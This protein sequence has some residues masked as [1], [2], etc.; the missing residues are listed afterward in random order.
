ME[1]LQPLRTPKVAPVASVLATTVDTVVPMHQEHPGGFELWQAA[2]NGDFKNVERA[3]MYDVRV[4]W[5]LPDNDEHALTYKLRKAFS[6]PIHAGAMADPP[7]ASETIVR[8]LLKA[9]ASVKAQCKICSSD[10]QTVRDITPMHLASGKGNVDTILALLEHDADVNEPA[11]LNGKLHYLPIHDAVWFN[12]ANSMRCL[13][14]KHARIEASNNAGNTALHLAAQLGHVKIA[15]ILLCEETLP[16]E[17]G[18][19]DGVSLQGTSSRGQETPGDATLDSSARL[20]EHAG[21]M[22]R[23]RRSKN[24]ASHIKECKRLVTIKNRDGKTPLDLAVEK[25]QFPPRELH[26]F[27]TCLDPASKVNAFVTIAKLCPAAAPALIRDRESQDIDDFAYKS[28]SKPWQSSLRDG[29]ANQGI[30]V[31][32]LAQL[33]EHA[34]RA[35]VALLDA[36]TGLPEVRNR[37]HNPLP[38]RANIPLGNDAC[39]IAC[40][41]EPVQVWEW[42]RETLQP[43][44]LRLA[45]QGPQALKY[46]QEVEVKVLKMKGVVD[47][48]VMHCLALAPDQRIFT[49]LVIHALIKVAW[50]NFQLMFLID[51]GHQLLATS[52]ISYWSCGAM[53]GE[54]HTSRFERL[55]WCCVASQGVVECFLFAWTSIMCLF[56]LS[57]VKFLHYA[58]RTFHRGLAGILTLSLAIQYSTTYGPVHESDMILAMN[59][60]THWMLLLYE[61]RAFQ[62]TGKRLLPIMRSVTPISGMLVIMLFISLAFVHAFWAMDRNNVDEPSFFGV[63]LLLFTGAAEELYSAED[64]REMG[65]NRS[66]FLIILSIMALLVFLAIV[67]NVFIAVLGDCYDQEQERMICTYLQERARICSGFFLRPC[68]QCSFAA[69]HQPKLLPRIIV[70]VAMLT[71]AGAL[72]AVFHYALRADFSAWVPAMLVVVVIVLIQSLLRGALTSGWEDNFLWMCHEVHVEE[73]MFLNSNHLV[74]RHLVEHQGRITQIKRYI[75]EQ[76]MQMEFRQSS[77]QKLLQSMNVKSKEAEDTLRRHGEKLNRL[78]STVGEINDVR[79]NRNVRRGTTQKLAV[80]QADTSMQLANCHE[81]E[82]VD[83]EGAEATEAPPLSSTVSYRQLKGVGRKLHNEVAEVWKSVEELRTQMCEQHE[84]QLRLER[85]MEGIAASLKEVRDIAHRRRLDRKAVPTGEPATLR[86]MDGA[87]TVEEATAPL[88]ASGDALV[89]ECTEPP[90]R[91]GT[92]P[93]VVDLS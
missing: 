13:L 76:A 83:H 64:L 19:G 43:W 16:S 32:T 20:G 36:L 31:A 25:G 59:S 58:A 66:Q 1:T 84:S 39:R 74:E 26:L 5:E 6:Q 80:L 81:A 65:G 18:T 79:S 88:L 91:S 29:A 52:T 71:T 60:L 51:L 7:S 46:G 22:D 2:R 45:P 53:A 75:Y 12:Q 24:G 92:T 61:L 89:A 77:C 56:H 37:E 44:Q 70:L 82:D 57:F 28:V 30:T 27:T 50:T 90:S 40:A 67:L 33:I 69:L 42:I 62:W 21:A 78:V 15:Q 87:P 9:R 4:D 23:R 10:G 35:A 8:A 63:I 55:L 41:Y 14:E 47:L 73:G 93:A 85:I 34:P 68:L 3:L 54:P 86:L 72:L 11:L 38:I 17:A 49:K 48:E